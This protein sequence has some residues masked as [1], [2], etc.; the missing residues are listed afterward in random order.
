MK[1]L[2]EALRVS[3][4]LL[5][6]TRGIKEYRRVLFASRTYVAKP[7]P[8][9]V[10]VFASPTSHWK[11]GR[12]AFFEG[13]RRVSEGEFILFESSDDHISMIAPENAEVNA[14]ILEAYLSRLEQDYNELADEESRRHDSRAA[15]SHR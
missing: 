15:A 6:S 5:R 3:T 14:P 1:L 12:E 8:G 7:Y 11:F 10:L 9:R 13:W 4:P 2:G